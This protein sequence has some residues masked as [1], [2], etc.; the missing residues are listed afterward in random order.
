MADSVV[1]CKSSS[2]AQLVNFVAI[3]LGCGNSASED[4][5]DS[6]DNSSEACSMHSLARGLIMQDIYWSPFPRPTS[7]CSHHHYG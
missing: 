6:C 3:G 1:D 4:Y 7:F 2:L 5:I